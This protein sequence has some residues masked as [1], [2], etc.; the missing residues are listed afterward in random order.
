MPNYFLISWSHQHSHC[1]EGKLNNPCGKVGW[2]WEVIF[3]C[4]NLCLC[5]APGV[6]GC[7][8]PQW[9]HTDLQMSCSPLIHSLWNSLR[10]L[11]LKGSFHSSLL[12]VTH[13]VS[14]WL[15]RDS[16]KE[17]FAG[18]REKKKKKIV[19]LSL[20]SVHDITGLRCFGITA[21]Q[22][23]IFPFFLYKNHKKPWQWEGKQLCDAFIL[24]W[25]CQRAGKWLSIL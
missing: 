12:S 20:F 8:K 10:D 7:R 5:A 2:G 14:L 21:S 16:W 18:K 24:E 15:Q 9:A 17:M 4:W 1:P 22:W 3:P 6:R 13:A 19:C 25:A 23:V 11:W